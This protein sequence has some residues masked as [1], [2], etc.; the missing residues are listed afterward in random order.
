MA[1]YT[2]D[3][4][5][6]IIQERLGQ[7]SGTALE[8]QILRE[9]KAAQRRVESRPFLPWF[10]LTSVGLHIWT[11]PSVTTIPGYIRDRDEGDSIYVQNSDLT[12]TALVK[13][14]YDHLMDNPD[15][16]GLTVRGRGKPQFYSRVGR[17]LYM[18]PYPD[19]AYWFTIH[20]FK[21]DD[22][23]SAGTPTNLWTTY[24][25]EVIINE[26]GY[27]VARALREKDATKFFQEDLIRAL[28]DMENQHIA[29][30]EAGLNAYMGG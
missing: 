12:Y 18:F 25:P 7:R 5:V 30:N 26:A 14:D 11:S 23:L 29:Y 2:R 6:E 1:A 3:E 15:L 17:N 16:N 20:Y 9:I 24:A 27:M 22:E 10:L 4:I 8:T 13:D 19:V 21:Q 28:Q